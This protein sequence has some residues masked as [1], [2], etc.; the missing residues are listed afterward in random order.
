MAR[1]KRGVQAKARHKKVLKQAKGY[2]GAQSTFDEPKGDSSRI[3][4]NSDPELL[5][6]VPNEG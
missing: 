5:D 1:V 6:P 2:R 3:S 4:D